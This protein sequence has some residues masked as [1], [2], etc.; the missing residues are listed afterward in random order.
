MPPLEVCSAPEGT[1]YSV[2]EWDCRIRG[3]SSIA[4]DPHKQGFSIHP[5]GAIVFRDDELFES[6]R[7]TETVSGYTSSGYTFSGSKTGSP[8]ATTW[9][10]FQ[11]LGKDGYT[12]LS[13]KC[14]DLTMNFVRGV[15][16][17]QGLDTATTPKINMAT[18]VSTTLDMSPVKRELEK[19]GWFFFDIKGKPKTRENAAMVEI[20]PYNEQNIPIFLNDLEE[21]VSRAR[22]TK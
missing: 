17:I 16:K 12:R 11:Y 7:W 9:A 1:K 2:S 8:I 21:I 4:S 15:R 10:I 22:K 14:M 5:A 6:A 18:A 3:V 19:R 13:R 20:V